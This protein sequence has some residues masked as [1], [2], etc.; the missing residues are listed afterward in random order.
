MAGVTD[1]PYRRIARRYGAGLLYSE[2]ISAEGVRRE[3]KGSF[4]LCRFAE[5]ERPIAIQLFGSDPE[6]FADA[7]VM[8]EKKYHPDMIDINCGCPVKRFVTRQCGGYLMQHPML[9]ADIVTTVLKAT[10]LPVSV[11]LRS[12]Y[13]FP[14]E[15]A[16]EAA[17]AAEEAGASV[18]AVH[19][20][21]VRNSNNSAAEWAVIK[22]V[23]AAVKRIPVIGNGDIVSFDS[24]RQMKEETGCDRVMIARWAYGQPW[25]FEN[26]KDDVNTYDEREAPSKE[27]KLDVLLDHYRLMLEHYTE[28]NA[29]MLMRKHI[30]WYTKGMAGSG[31]FR[32]EMMEIN[33]AQSVL[34][35][36]MEYRLR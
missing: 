22:R 9:I 26:L 6:Q 17:V 7:T 18:V 28:R 14:E 5:E 13:R 20:R 32:G 4:E 34:D 33:D 2:C 15:T 24:V 31:R 29:V 8:I 19:G 30:G 16:V 23:K 25:L 11:K 3:G 27:M 36:V 21:Y 1:S 35:K 12:G 10:K